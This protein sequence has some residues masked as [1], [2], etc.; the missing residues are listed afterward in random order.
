M[1][2]TRPC[3]KQPTNNVCLC[4]IFSRHYYSLLLSQLE[5][6]FQTSWSCHRCRIHINVFGS[7]HCAQSLFSLSSQLKTPAV[8]AASLSSKNADW[9]SQWGVFSEW[10]CKV[11]T[12]KVPL[13]LEEGNNLWSGTS[14]TSA[15]VD[16]VPEVVKNVTDMTNYCSSYCH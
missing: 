12:Y 4:P 2:F 15:G 3:G 8:A 14:K 10:I 6:V 5:N 9:C 11:W 13:E 1:Y 16:F 7:R